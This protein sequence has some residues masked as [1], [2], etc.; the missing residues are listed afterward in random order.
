MAVFG[1]P[2][3][4]AEVDVVDRDRVLEPLDYAVGM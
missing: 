4:Q 3:E 2:G 1:G